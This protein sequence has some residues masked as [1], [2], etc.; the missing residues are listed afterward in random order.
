MILRPDTHECVLIQGSFGLDDVHAVS[1]LDAVLLA[2]E[3]FE[4][5]LQSLWVLDASKMNLETRDGLP[6]V[7]A[8]DIPW[9]WDI[10]GQLHSLNR[11]DTLA[12]R[13]RFEFAD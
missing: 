3:D 2:T 10:G 8:L 9:I 13:K 5:R 6:L 7:E 1:Y 12:F 4:K 11:P